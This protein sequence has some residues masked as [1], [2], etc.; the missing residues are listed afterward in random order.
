MLCLHPPLFFKIQ[1]KVVADL[2]GNKIKS[3]RNP[4]YLFAYLA[5]I[6]MSSKR[7]GPNKRK[8]IEMPIDPTK[9][10]YQNSIKLDENPSVVHV[11]DRRLHVAMFEGKSSPSMY[12]L[13]RAWVKDDPD[14][15]S[16]CCDQLQLHSCN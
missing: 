9:G 4:S 15:Y 13:F 12:E 7:T 5:R 8:R 10:R 11:N 3:V 1:S 14:S 16:V 2:V 6:L